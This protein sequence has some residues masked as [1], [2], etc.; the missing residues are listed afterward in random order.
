MFS[1]D[2]V[3]LLRINQFGAMLVSNKDYSNNRVGAEKPS[4]VINS[5]FYYG[6]VPE[7]INMSP[8]EVTLHT[9]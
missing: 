9:K 3:R 5:P 1:F 6:G 8:L 2:Q 4:L 7:G